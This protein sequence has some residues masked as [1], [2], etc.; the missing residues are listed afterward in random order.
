M[1][2]LKKLSADLGTVSDC[3]MISTRSRIGRGKVTRHLHE[4]DDEK[5]REA[6][7]SS[8]LPCASLVNII[9]TEEYE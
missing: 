6:S 8:P 2:S 9:E 3:L 1:T 4:G 7:L 5:E